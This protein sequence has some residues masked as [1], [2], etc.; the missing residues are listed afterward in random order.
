MLDEEY[1]TIDDDLVTTSLLKT[2]S[3][4]IDNKRV[5]DILLPLVN[6]GPAAPFIKQYR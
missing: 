4:K 6:T 3:A 5:F 1:D 2:K